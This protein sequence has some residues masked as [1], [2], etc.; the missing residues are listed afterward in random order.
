[1]NE[2][3]PKIN[4]VDIIN[5]SREQKMKTKSKLHT[6]INLLLTDKEKYQIPPDNTPKKYIKTNTVNQLKS[7]P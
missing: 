7:P 3:S 5:R 6:T 2:I 4:L 1:M